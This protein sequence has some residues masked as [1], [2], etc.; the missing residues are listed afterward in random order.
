[1]RAN[2]TIASMGCWSRG[3]FIL[4]VPLGG[5]EPPTS[6]SRRAESSQASSNART[7]LFP[8]PPMQ[9]VRSSPRPWKYRC[10]LVSRRFLLNGDYDVEIA[11]SGE[12]NEA[13]GLAPA[14]AY[15]SPLTATASF[16]FN[17]NGTRSESRDHNFTENIQL[18]VRAI[19][20]DW[21]TGLYPRG[22]PFGPAC[23]L[24][25]LHPQ[26]PTIA[27]RDSRWLSG[28]GSASSV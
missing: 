10:D 7:Q 6:C 25:A 16:L 5:L 4:V 21:E 18:S 11:L 13:G 28:P 9:A 22:P 15:M 12:V 19:Y 20:A 27:S 24:P 23:H 8:G 3:Q 1:M 17:A 2:K 14:L 26:F